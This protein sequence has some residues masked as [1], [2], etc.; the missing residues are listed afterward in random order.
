MKSY[1]RIKLNII[2]KNWGQ[3]GKVLVMHMTQYQKSPNFQKNKGK[4]L[5]FISNLGK[6][7]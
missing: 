7:N 2:E 5:S 1:K 6:E 3:G 4:L